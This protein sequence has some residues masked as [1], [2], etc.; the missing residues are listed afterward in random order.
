M[1]YSDRLKKIN[2]AKGIIGFLTK[3]N[4][5]YDFIYKV[6]I[7]SNGKMINSMQMNKLRGVREFKL[8]FDYVRW[9]NGD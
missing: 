8:H 6:P 1:E 2:Y 3:D 7:Q 9:L 4:E 5:E